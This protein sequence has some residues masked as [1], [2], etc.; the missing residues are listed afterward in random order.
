MIRLTF[1]QTVIAAI[2]LLLTIGGGAG[3][4]WATVEHQLSVSSEQYGSLQQEASDQGAAIQQ[5]RGDEQHFIETISDQLGKLS[6]QLTDLRVL[7]AAKDHAP[8]HQR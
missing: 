1:L 2:V 6:D 8:A 3:T 7:V 5:L 4:L